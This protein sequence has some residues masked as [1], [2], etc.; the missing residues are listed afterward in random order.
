MDLYFDRHR[1]VLLFTLFFPSFTQH[2]EFPFIKRRKK[3]HEVV[4]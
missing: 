1:T 3:E 2:T 4:R